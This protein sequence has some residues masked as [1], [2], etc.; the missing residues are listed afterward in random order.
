MPRITT[1]C[2][3]EKPLLPVAMI[4]H[5]TLSS[6]DIQESRRFYEEVLGLEVIQT[7]PVSL[8]LR[9]GTDQAYAVVETGQP[10]NHG[11]MDH[12]GLDVLTHEAV[13]E[14]YRLLTENKA[15]YGIKRITRPLEQHGAYSF[16]LV[17]RDGNWWEIVNY[18]PRG[19]APLFEDPARDI[20]G[21]TDV[22]VDLLDSTGSDEY[23]DS[24]RSGRK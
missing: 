3:T 8:L 1:S 23:A 7:S 24:L 18:G 13:D 12:N 19:Y 2:R 14:S 9:L 22:D 4:S 11:L 17:D 15:K 6:L 20:T 10:S 16:Y 21:R 5:G